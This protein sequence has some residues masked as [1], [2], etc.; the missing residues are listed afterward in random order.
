VGSRSSKEVNAGNTLLQVVVSAVNFSGFSDDSIL[1]IKLESQFC[2]L[3]SFPATAKPKTHI[4]DNHHH[5]TEKHTQSLH[6]HHSNPTSKA[7]KDAVEGNKG[8]RKG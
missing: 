7:G 2:R 3:K 6:H 5:H 8:A 4:N 1:P